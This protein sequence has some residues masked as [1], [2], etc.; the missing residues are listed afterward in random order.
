MTLIAN[1]NCLHLGAHLNHLESPTK[2]RPVAEKFI[3]VTSIRKSTINS[4][5]G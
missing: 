1:A 5:S 2:G 3:T 4:T